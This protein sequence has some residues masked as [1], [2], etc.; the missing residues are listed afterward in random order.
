MG[1]RP[2]LVSRGKRSG[3]AA[4]RHSTGCSPP[5]GTLSRLCSASRLFV[6]FY[7]P[8]FKLAEKV[9]VGA[10]VTKR[11]HAPETPCARLLRSTAMTAAMKEQLQAAAAGLDPLALLDEIRSMQHHLSALASAKLVISSPQRDCDLDR[12]IKSHATAWQQG[13]VRPAH[14]KQSKPRRDWRTRQ[15]PFEA[16]WLRVVA[17]LEVE[18]DRTKP[19]ILVGMSV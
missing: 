2:R 4:L 11:Y 15:D 12:Y 14:R 18:P 9:R 16:A 19:T 8:S 1:Q 6:N 5:S 7:Q 10:R 17:W 13:D 3:T